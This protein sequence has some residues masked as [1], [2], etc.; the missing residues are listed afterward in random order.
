MPTHLMFLAFAGFHAPVLRSKSPGAHSVTI[1]SATGVLL[2]SDVPPHWFQSPGFTVG[3]FRFVGSTAVRLSSIDLAA[4]AVVGA[5]LELAGFA[6]ALFS[7]AG[8]SVALA[9]AGLSV[10]DFSSAGLSSAGL[11]SAGFS[12]LISVLGISIWGEASVVVLVVPSDL[13]RGLAGWHPDRKVTTTAP[14]KSAAMMAA[15]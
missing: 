11:S 5:A 3:F 8:L 2:R 13:P 10:A 6:R 4:T 14:K 12:S 7:S 15:R 1:P 9:S